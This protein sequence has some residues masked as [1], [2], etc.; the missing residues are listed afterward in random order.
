MAN[1]LRDENIVVYR[2]FGSGWSAA[3]VGGV[4]EDVE[5]GWRAG[6]GDYVP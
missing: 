2:Q 6:E 1:I 4:G 3:A 5:G